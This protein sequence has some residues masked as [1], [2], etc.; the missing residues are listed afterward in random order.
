[1]KKFSAELKVGLF[2][3]ASIV[4]IIFIGIKFGTFKFGSRYTVH[5][6]FP[7]AQGVVALGSVQIAGVPIGRV[8]SIRYVDRGARMA[9]SINQDVQLHADATATIRPKSLLGEKVVELT[10]GSPEAPLME[11]H[12]EIV[13]V[14]PSTDVSELLNQAGQMFAKFSPAMNDFAKS[15]S[16]INEVIS[17]GADK[18][19]S[20]ANVATAI[21]D[22]ALLI[23]NVRTFFQ[24]HEKEISTTVRNLQQLTDKAKPALDDISHTSAALR[25]LTDSEKENLQTIIRNGKDITVKLNQILTKMND[26]ETEKRVKT[27]LDQL[28]KVL[29]KLGKSWLL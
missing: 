29:N 28:E 1:M 16:K 15:L 3:L 25:Q 26:P 22:S 7:H 13:N 8:E 23:R 4:V 12:G 10:P 9:M 6:T 2:V 17:G 18:G 24:T 19:G 11:D 21:Q 5:A 27:L 14:L 20:Q